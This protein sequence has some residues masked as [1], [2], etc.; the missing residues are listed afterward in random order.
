MRPTERARADSR[1]ANAAAKAARRAERPAPPPDRP[2]LLGQAAGRA[3]PVE[4]HRSTMAH[5]CSMYPF[6]AD[7]G[8]GEAGVYFGPNITAGLD[9]FFY[10]PF[11][12]YNAGL[13]EN[14]NIKVCGTIGSAK[15]GTVKAMIKRTRA[16]YPDRFIAV[17][18]PK[19]E[20]TPLAEWL[21]I[22][23]V[24]LQPGGRHQLN[25]MEADG[26]GNPADALLARE[27]LATSLVGGVLGRP[28]QQIEEAVLSWAIGDLSRRRTIFTIRDLNDTLDHPDADLLRMARLSPLE[29]AKVIADVRFALQ[30]LCDRTLRGMFDGPTNVA[31]DWRDGPGVVLDL[32]AVHNDAQVLPLV[33]LAATYWLGEAMRRP[34]RQKLQ[35]IDEAWA[36][37]RH[38]AGYVQSS[39]KLSRQWGV[40][41]VLISHRPRDLAAQNDDGTAASKIAAGLLGDIE[42]RILLRQPAE[43]VPAMAALFDLSAREQDMLSMLPTG[44]AIWKIGRRSAVVQTVRSQVERQLFWTDSAMASVDDA[45]GVGAA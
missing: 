14:P 17:L 10:D 23:V 27:G 6:Q 20:Y 33:M 1:A 12:F 16:V 19:G 37:V 15:S 34:G 26:N 39:L 25:P 18:D 40:A 42:T 41:N 21:S 2:S 45:D 36:A 13:V 30:K 38:G 24:K 11:E 32:S 43:E 4:W 31:V 7:R 9:G 28:L 44:R 35:V 22:P 8:F 29:M 3:I 5:L